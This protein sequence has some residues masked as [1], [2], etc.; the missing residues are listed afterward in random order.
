MTLNHAIK[1][2]H[3]PTLPVLHGSAAV[4][5]PSLTWFRPGGVL[6]HFEV[7]PFLPVKVNETIILLGLTEHEDKG[8]RTTAN[9][10]NI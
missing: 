4:R 9:L 6:P 10:F 3:T 1:T 5:F 7:F 2:E 8:L